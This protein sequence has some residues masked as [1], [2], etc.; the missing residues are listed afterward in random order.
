[1]ILS[2]T[3]NLKVMLWS[4]GCISSLVDL[5]DCFLFCANFLCDLPGCFKLESVQSSQNGLSY[6]TINLINS[7]RTV[8]LM[9]Q[10]DCAINTFFKQ[11]QKLFETFWGGSNVFYWGEMIVYTSKTCPDVKKYMYLLR[12]RAGN[13]G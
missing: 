3:V 1:L 4:W 12:M 6:Y 2:Y 11:A 8:G 9:I 7:E 13:N 5:K 10:P